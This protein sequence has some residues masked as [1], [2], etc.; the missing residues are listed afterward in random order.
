LHQDWGSSHGLA[1]L[2]TE[3]PVV[4]QAV[5]DVVQGAGVARR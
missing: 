4:L 2:L 5:E 3:L 1:R